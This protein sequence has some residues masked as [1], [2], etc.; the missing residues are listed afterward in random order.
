LVARSETG[1]ST[2]GVAR[3]ETG[4]SAEVGD[5]PQRRGHNA[6]SRET[7]KEIWMRC[8]FPCTGAHLSL[9]KGGS[10]MDDVEV[11]VRSVSDI[12]NSHIREGMS[13]R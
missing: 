5:R 1:H 8:D 2:R 10:A 9:E 4:H 13:E 6:Q 11:D 3:S 7:D 12:R